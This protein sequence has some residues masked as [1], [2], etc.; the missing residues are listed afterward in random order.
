MLFDSRN[1]SAAYT[2]AVR[3]LNAPMGV[4]FSCFTHTSAPRRSHSRGQ[5]NCGVGGITSYTNCCA[6]L[7]SSIVG[8]A[9]AANTCLVTVASAPLLLIVY[10]QPCCV[11][12]LSFD[13]HRCDFERSAS[14]LDGESHQIGWITNSQDTQAANKPSG[15]LRRHA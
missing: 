7:I 2:I 8:R 5:T 13:N 12:D 10:S 14:T 6:S 9:V 11:E 1:S 15:V 4:W 3:A